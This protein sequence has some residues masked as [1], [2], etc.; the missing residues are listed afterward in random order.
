[1][2]GRSASQMLDS[3]DRSNQEPRLFDSHSLEEETRL[4]IL[5]EYAVLDTGP[6]AGFD[7]ITLLASR[8]CDTP[9][10]LMSLVDSNRLFFKS[11]V[12]V[13]AQEVPFPHAFCGHTIKQRNVFVVPDCRADGRFAQHPLVINPPH[14]RFYAGAPLITPTDHSIGT[15]CVIDHV[16]RT[17]NAVQHLALEILARQIIVQLEQRK[18]ISQLTE[19]LATIKT[20]RGLLPICAW[21]KKVRQDDGYWEQLEQYIS[22]HSDASFSHSICPDCRT[23]EL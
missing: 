1:L 10:A 23:K 17:V 16:P 13:E 3:E 7:E 20:L 15:L 12:G 5:R 4:S 18:I 11:H 9:I 6:E 8:I 22:H 21:C 2:L 19:S 14:I